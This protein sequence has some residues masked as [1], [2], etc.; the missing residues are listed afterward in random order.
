LEEW[1]AARQIGAG[2]ETERITMSASDNKKL[3]E[4]IFA[5]IAAGDRTLFVESLADDVMMR[6]T[7]QNSWSQTF[8]GKDALLRD[9]YGYL[10]TLLVADRRT[11]PLRFIAD[12]DHVV[13]QATGEMRTKAG[14][15]YN[16]DYCLIYR[17]RDGRITEITEYL[18]SA[19]CERVLG[20]FPAAS[21]PAAG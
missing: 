13:V 7:G 5:R 1:R 3:I 2:I 16:N 4:T 18:D 19:L 12:G 8:R 6:V 14:V 17:L 9:L 11:V 20:P 10:G 21:K 15:P